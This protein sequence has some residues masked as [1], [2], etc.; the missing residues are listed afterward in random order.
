[1]LCKSAVTV[2]TTRLGTAAAQHKRF[3]VAG[4]MA[5]FQRPDAELQYLS[6]VAA[7]ALEKEPESL[8]LLVSPTDAQNGTKAQAGV[9]LLAGPAGEAHLAFPF[10]FACMVTFS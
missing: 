4:G 7:S 9:F 5:S 1:M 10:R 6:L 3:C 2:T 8:L